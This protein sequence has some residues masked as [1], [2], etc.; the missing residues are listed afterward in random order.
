MTLRGP[1]PVLLVVPPGLLAAP[2]SDL[3]EAVA[4]LHLHPDDVS[5]DRI[6]RFVKRCVT[7]RCTNAEKKHG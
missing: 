6:L 3:A 4:V 2:A 7:W 1:Y 5:A